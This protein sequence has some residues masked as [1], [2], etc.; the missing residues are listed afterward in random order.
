MNSYSFRFQYVKVAWYIIGGLIAGPLLA[1]AAFQIN[2]K[3]LLLFLVSIFAPIIA[4]VWIA[5]KKSKAS[6]QVT[7][8]SDGFF[9]EFYG[10]VSYAD[11]KSISGPTIWVQTPIALIMKLKSGRKLIWALAAKSNMYNSEEDAATFNQFAEALSKKLE[12]YYET[13]PASGAVNSLLS[14]GAPSNSQ[15]PVTENPAQQLKKGISSRKAAKTAI[16]FASILVLVLALKNCGVDYIREKKNREVREIFQSSETRY[17]N[18]VESA[19][20]ILDSMQKASG[21]VYVYTNDSGVTLHLMPDINTENAEMLSS[22][23]VLAHSSMTDSLKKFVDHPDSFNYDIIL[24]TERGKTLT[25]RKSVLNYNDSADSWLYLAC[26]DPDLKITD[27]GK[28]SEDSLSG[29]SKVFSFATGIPVYPDKSLLE[30]IDG[31]TMNFKM[32]L[33]RTKFNKHY[34]V[35]LMA[36]SGKDHVSESL[37][38]EAMLVFNRQLSDI[39]GDTAAFHFSIR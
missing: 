17:Y 8:D 27:D 1:L 32:L 39:K 2:E 38:R 20:L 29:N 31:A 36:V 35:Y 25:V 18:T 19:K 34:K 21:P 5:V 33:A 15:Q 9:S 24:Q 10:R 3:S 23:P 14:G 6:D 26:Y 16:P 28:I 4:A 30:S 7:L 13:H 12:T 22:V 37:F 11:I